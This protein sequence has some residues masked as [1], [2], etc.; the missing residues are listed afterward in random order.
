IPQSEKVKVCMPR[1]RLDFIFLRKELFLTRA[2]RAVRN[3]P[4]P[5]LVSS[6]K[7]HLKAINSIAFINL[8]KIIFS[9]SHDYSC[10]LWTLGGRYLGT[11]GTVLPW[12]K[13]SPFERAGDEERAYRLPPDIKKVASSTTLKVISG[14][15]AERV[16]KRAK[17]TEE[18]EEEREVEADAGAEMKNMFDRPLREPI[19]GKH[20]Q[21]P[22]RSAVEQRIELDTTQLYIPVYTHLKVYPSDLQ[23]TLPMPPIIGQVKNENYLEHYLPVQGKID[24]KASAVNIR[25]PPKRSR[26]G[27]DKSSE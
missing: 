1:L 21:L 19:L 5:L 27:K 2:K 20:F 17:P 18:R 25:E 9:G 24:P 4:E 3:Q 14:V 10:R 11:L 13:L 7:A 26:G 23:E 15:Q 6:F 8:P 12:T 16:V 22:G